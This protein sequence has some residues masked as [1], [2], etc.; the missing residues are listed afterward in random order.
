MSA[1]FCCS[2]VGVDSEGGIQYLISDAYDDTGS[3]FNDPVYLF[4]AEAY[5]NVYT[6]TDWGINFN[7]VKTD[8]PCTIWARAPGKMFILE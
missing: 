7:V 8:K 4:F 1:L 5:S 6:S 3:S 2:Q